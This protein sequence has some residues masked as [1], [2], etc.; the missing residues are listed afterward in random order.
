MGQN[1]QII[2]SQYQIYANKYIRGDSPGA[3]LAAIASA[4]AKD[5]ALIDPQNAA[6][7]LNQHHNSRRLL[8]DYDY[9]DESISNKQ[10]EAKNPNETPSAK[11]F[12]LTKKNNNSL[13]LVL[14]NG[15]WRLIDLD[16]CYKMMV[17][18]LHENN[19]NPKYHNYTKFVIFNDL[20]N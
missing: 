15:T 12:N 20:N 11:R 4:Q 16:I 10:D 19:T 5:G 18:E 6:A 9:T 1:N 3:Q 17:S 14:I 7:L 2:D 13:E 8:S